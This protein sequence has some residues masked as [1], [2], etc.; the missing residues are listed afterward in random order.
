MAEGNSRARNLTKRSKPV[1]RCRE[2][3]LMVEKLDLCDVCLFE[4][5]DE[6][7]NTFVLSWR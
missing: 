3:L 1:V 4:P 7:T 2:S 5:L 6:V